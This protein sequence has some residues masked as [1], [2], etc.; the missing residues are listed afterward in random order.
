MDLF[1]N[2]GSMFG[3]SVS[4]HISQDISFSKP[5]IFEAV[6]WMSSPKLF[7]E[8]AIQFLRQLIIDEGR[9]LTVSPNFETAKNNMDIALNDLGTRCVINKVFQAAAFVRLEGDIDQGVAHYNKALYYNW[10]YAD[11]MYNLGVAYGEMLSL[12]MAIVFSEPAF[13]FNPHYEET[14]NNLGVIY[15]D[16][17]NLDKAVQCYQTTLSIKPNFSQSLDNL[18]VVYTVQVKLEGDIDQGVAHYNKALYYNWHCADAMYNLGVAYGEM[19]RLDM[20]IVFYELAFHFNPHYAET[21]NNLGVIYKDRDNLDKAVQCY[22]TTLSIKPN[23]SQSLDNLGVVYTVQ[24]I[25]S[26]FLSCLIQASSS[27]LAAGNFV[28]F[29]EQE[30]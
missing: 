12:D 3:R 19:L 26:S 21:C 11:A 7:V 18:G 28:Y 4:S 27:P 10:H 8:S 30:H 14:C 6:G 22:Q 20:A 24:I 2:A 15:K 25:A 16:R 23:F 5:T 13:H 9:C 29:S 17:D 1:R